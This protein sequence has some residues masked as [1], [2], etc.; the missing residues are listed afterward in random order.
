M[1]LS[2]SWINLWTDLEVLDSV[3]SQVRGYSDSN[4][5]NCG[6]NR[7]SRILIVV[8]QFDLYLS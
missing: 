6:S 5:I 4:V 3:G 1:H 2:H 7:Y 8:V